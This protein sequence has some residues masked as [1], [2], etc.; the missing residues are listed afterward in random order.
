ME[1]FQETRFYT[2][3]QLF[4]MMS[5]KEFPKAKKQEPIGTLLEGGKL[6]HLKHKEPMPTL[7]EYKTK[8]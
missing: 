2:E 1:K 6:L 8:K 7:L 4:P 3:S 5:Q